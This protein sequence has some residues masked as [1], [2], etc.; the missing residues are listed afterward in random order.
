MLAHGSRETDAQAAF[1]ALAVQAAAAPALRG[2]AP[3][4]FQFGM[5]GL[6]AALSALAARG[7][8]EIAV[9]PFFLFSG[10]HLRHTVPELVA[11]WRTAHPGVRVKLL[12]PFGQDA[13][14]AALLAEQA[15]RAARETI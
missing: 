13:R 14:V 2:M 5:E 6:P 8:T 4:L 10:F 1:S 12:P 7:E 9:L 15:A 11:R 3:P